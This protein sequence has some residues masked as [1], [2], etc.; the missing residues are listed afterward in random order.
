MLFSMIFVGSVSAQSS[1]VIAV[2]IELQDLKEVDHRLQ[3]LKLLR[4]KSN[5]QEK[6]ISELEN[7][8]VIERKTNE[9]SEREIYLQK[10]II[11][12]KDME[13]QALNRNF[14]QMKE[15]ADR[16]IKLSETV[17]PKSNTLLYVIGGILAGLVAG[18]AIAL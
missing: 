3:E 7:S 16:A 14:D 10:K 8:L 11:E 17:K 18:L 4:Q 12:V 9:L 13:I 2:D 15:V 6:T 5:E 1:V